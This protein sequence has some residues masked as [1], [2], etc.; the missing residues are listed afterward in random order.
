MLVNGIARGHVDFRY[1][2]MREKTK[3]NHVLITAE[4]LTGEYA[5][6]WREA[7]RGRARGRF[8][9]ARPLTSLAISSKA[10]LFARR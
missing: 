3:I 6:C 10:E 2:V 7:P 1:Q 4:E 9:S 5:L 8:K